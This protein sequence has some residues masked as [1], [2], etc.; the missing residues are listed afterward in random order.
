[1]LHYM[2]T[3]QVKKEALDEVRQALIDFV[4][5]VKGNEP[6]TVLYAS[7]HKKDDPFSFIHFM[8]FENEG[9]KHQH[10][11]ADY[12]THFTELLS[13]CCTVQNVFTEL[14]LIR[15]NKVC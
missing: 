14:D 12:T 8:C 7:F 9:A 5:A 15:S 1:M 6:N 4:G 3:Y 11:S 13:R 2:A 10:E